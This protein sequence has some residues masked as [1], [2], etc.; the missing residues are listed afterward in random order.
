MLKSVSQQS[1]D[2]KVCLWTHGNLT[3]TFVVFGN[4][5]G[6]DWKEVPE[7]CMFEKVTNVTGKEGNTLNVLVRLQRWRQWLL[8]APDVF[9]LTDFYVICL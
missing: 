6:K 9:A 4:L 5:L 3:A 8:M 7:Q 1:G 2:T